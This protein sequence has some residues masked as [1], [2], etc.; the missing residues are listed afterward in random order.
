MANSRPGR[1]FVSKKQGGQHLRSNTWSW[2]LS[3][4]WHMHTLC[5]HTNRYVHTYIHIFTKESSKKKR[6]GGNKEKAVKIFLIILKVLLIANIYKA[7]F[8]K[9]LDGDFSYFILT[10]YRVIPFIICI[11]I[12][13]V[14]PKSFVLCRLTFVGKDALWILLWTSHCHFGEHHVVYC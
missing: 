10:R 9:G 5:T 4:T 11:S 3:F 8:S 13:W 1:E 14:Q 2:P 12:N 6:W 7:G